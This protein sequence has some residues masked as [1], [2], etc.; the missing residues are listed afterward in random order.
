MDSRLRGNDIKGH[1]RRR[2]DVASFLSSIT[3][4][5]KKSRGF[6]QLRKRRP[7]TT[8]ATGEK[9]KTIQAPYA[10]TGENVPHA[11]R[12]G[13]IARKVFVTSSPTWLLTLYLSF[14]A[15]LLFPASENSINQ[16]APKGQ[17]AP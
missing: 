16:N 12:N 11:F 2:V 15:D 4:Q 13:R 8:R 9:Q 3:H 17:A 5:K 14:A 7:K 6:P 1:N 10:V